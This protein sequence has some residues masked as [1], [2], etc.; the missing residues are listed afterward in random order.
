MPLGGAAVP[1][2]VAAAGESWEPRA[3]ELLGQRGSG[4]AV[5]RRCVDLHDL[6]ASSRTGLARAAVVSGVLPGLD[7]D[8]LDTLRRAGVGVVVVL[9]VGGGDRDR[10]ERLGA[11]RVVEADL[12]DLVQALV[13]AQDDPVADGLAQPG[14]G[15]RLATQ[16]P[17]DAAGGTG[18]LLAVWG[19]A[20]APGRTTLAT[21]VAAELAHRGRSTF[22]VDADPYG[23]AVGQ[24]LGVLDEV[25]G[26]LAAARAANAGRLDP[27]ALAGIARSVGDEGLRVLTGLPR[28][29]RWPEVRAAAF[30][31]VLRSATALAAEVVVD[32]GFSLEADAADPFGTAPQRNQMTLGALERAG[33]VLVVGSAD[34][35]GL[36]RLARGLVDLG[37][38]LPGVATH[39][40]VNRSRPS[41]GWSETEVRGMVEGFVG[42]VPVTFVPEDRATADRALMSGRSPVELGDSPLRRALADL[43]DE[44]AGPRQPTGGGAGARVRR[45]RAG[46]A[47]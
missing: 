21:G 25:S 5:H 17:A 22:L 27:A 12:E 37:D 6:L 14:A 44:L 39:V 1:V 31:D 43:V 10:L 28:P 8:A 41:L 32:V 45:R 38:R 3:L 29:D 40:V 24:H 46:R 2:L 33:L 34:P 20:G 47:R 23:G 19:P 16:P 30:D 26:L 7:A 36:A 13:D 9:P 15:D 4:L 35:V 11:H 42:P 18:R